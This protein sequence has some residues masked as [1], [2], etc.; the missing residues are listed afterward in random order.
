MYLTSDNASWNLQ[1]SIETNR[2]DWSDDSWYHI[3]MVRNGT[4][5]KVYVN[6]VEDYSFTISTT[7][8]ADADGVRIGRN[9][10]SGVLD[11]DGYMDEIRISNTARYTAAF[12]PKVRGE[13]F[14]RRR[15]HQ[16][17]DTL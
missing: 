6:G 15:K 7:A 11:L 8:L 10:G 9:E 16:T 2:Q 1:D 4:T 5:V 12:T 17:T 3:A 14:D 13:P